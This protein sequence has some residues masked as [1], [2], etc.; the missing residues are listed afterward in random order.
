[1]SLPCQVRRMRGIPILRILVNTWLLVSL[2][3]VSGC[4]NCN[5]RAQWQNNGECKYAKTIHAA[6]VAPCAIH[7]AHPPLAQGPTAVELAQQASVLEE[8]HDPACVD[9][10]FA[11]T[12]QSWQPLAALG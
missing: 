6:A 2:A 4:R 7:A 9:L 3:V 1:M 11:A 10:Y 5:K 12:Y 8:A